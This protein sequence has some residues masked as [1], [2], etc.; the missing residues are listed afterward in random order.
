MTQVRTDLDKA[1]ARSTDLQT[2]VAG[3]KRQQSDTQAKLTASENQVTDLQGKLDKS[4]SDLRSLRD[5]DQAQATAFQSR[6]SQANDRA[7]GLQRQL[8]QAK[9]RADDLQA[10]LTKAQDADAQR[11][12]APV[13]AAVLPALPVTAEFKKGFLSDK[14]TMHLRNTGGTALKVSV[15]AAG[16]PAKSVNVDAG[17]TTEVGDLAAG[18][19]L[20]ISSDGFSPI[21][22]TVQ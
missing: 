19:A 12:S 22:T 20:V 9:S 7:T 13:A 18:T 6:L 8:D 17:K 15:S 16:S 11:L 1:N 3:A 10:Q 14:Y 21:N 2:Q 4:G 5:R